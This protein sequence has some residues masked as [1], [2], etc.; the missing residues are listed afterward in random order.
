MCP[1]RG[2]LK[3]ACHNM[4]LTF[5]MYEAAAAVICMTSASLYVCT[6]WEK[7]KRERPLPQASAIWLR[8]I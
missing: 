5:M 7:R 2:S 1:H 8:D 3:V 4:M 6:P